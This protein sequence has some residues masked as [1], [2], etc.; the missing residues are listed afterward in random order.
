MLV[1]DSADKSSSLTDTEISVEITNMAFAA[2]DT[3][4]NTFTYLFWELAKHPEWQ[5]H[6]R[7]ELKGV[8]FVSGIPSYKDVVQLPVLDALIQEVLRLH[9]AAPTS[10]QRF[11][12]T[13]EG[14]V[15]GVVVPAKVGL[16]SITSAQVFIPARRLRSQTRGRN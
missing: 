6:L 16:L 14:K 5:S 10:L 1:E 2:T 8:N 11:N 4:G 3:T 13:S 15:A 12:P 7:K 9:P